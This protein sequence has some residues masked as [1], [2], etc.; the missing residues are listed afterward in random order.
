MII[1]GENVTVRKTPTLQGEILGFLSYDLVKVVYESSLSK[2]TIDG[3][4]HPWIKI[5]STEGVIG[6]VYGKYIRSPIDYR[7]NFVKKDNT[8]KIVFFLAGD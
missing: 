4:T 7:V 2:E 3:E 6:Y 1:I 5:K 8:W